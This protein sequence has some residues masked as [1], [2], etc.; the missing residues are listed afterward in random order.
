TSHTLNDELIMKCHKLMQETEDLSFSSESPNQILENSMVQVTILAKEGKLFP[1]Q[2]DDL[3]NIINYVLAQRI[4]P[5]S[6]KI[7]ILQLIWWTKMRRE[8]NTIVQKF[9]RQATMI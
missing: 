3:G 4:L 9:P 1:D 2:L 6:L 5:D 7:Y 8:G